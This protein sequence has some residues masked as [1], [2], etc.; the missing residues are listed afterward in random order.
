MYWL[1]QH[2]RVSAALVIRETAARYGS[3]PGGYIWALLDPLAHV[4]MM[5]T[6]YQ[7]LARTPALGTDFSL[8]FASGYL[9]FSVYQ[10][11]SSF[12]SSAIR[13]NKNLFSYPVVS[14]F[15]AVVGRYIL[16]LVT[17]VL[18]MIVVFAICTS[19]PQRLGQLDAGNAVLV[20]ML[21]SMLGVGVGMANVALFNDFPLYEKIF[22]LL[23]RPIFM[24]SGV[25]FLPDMMPRP[26]SDILLW[27]PLSHITMWFRT[28]IYPEYTA[29][30]LDKTYVI[31]FAIALVM[32][33]LTLFTISKSLRED[34]I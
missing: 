23:N 22:T 24:M 16:Q 2:A 21:A 9:P 14:P 10:Q 6:I 3:K 17:S 33:G 27:N 20:I 5:T 7:T 12:V 29:T 1:I 25:L 26:Y 13:A 11:M 18:V 30:G 31:E 28:A 4:L 34:R 32:I 8:F 19:E 15:D